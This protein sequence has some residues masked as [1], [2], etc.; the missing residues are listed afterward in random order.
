MPRRIA[1]FACLIAVLT[2][3]LLEAHG[4]SRQKVAKEILVQAPAAEVW[5]IIADF[6][7]IERWHP[8]VAKCTG[9]G[10][11]GPGAKRTLNI[12]T[13]DGPRIEEELQIH[14]PAAMT[15]K[16]KI[17]KTDNAVLPVTTYS[18]FLSVAE[19]GNGTSTVAWRGGFYRAHPNNNPPPD[20]NDEAAL[21]AVTA[22][23]E[24]GLAQIKALAEQ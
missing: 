23:Y 1:R 8:A 7:A 20:L 5:A 9:E 2:P 24:A 19:A 10:G 13:A 4:P 17:V 14:D 15:Y 12:G 22:V 3:G 11:N 6:C 21:A 16:Y 18:A